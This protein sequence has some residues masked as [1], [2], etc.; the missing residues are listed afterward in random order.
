[1]TSTVLYFSIETPHLVDTPTNQPSPWSYAA[2]GPCCP[3]L[4]TSWHLQWLTLTLWKKTSLKKAWWQNI[5]RQVGGCRAQTSPSWE[6]RICQTTTPSSW[7]TLDLWGSDKTENGRSYTVRTSHDTLIRRNRVQLLLDS[8]VFNVIPLN[9][10]LSCKIYMK[11][12]LYWGCRWKW[13]MIIA[14]NFP[15]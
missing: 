7:K 14:V 11:F 5:L 4:T 1:M 3:P 9:K 2:L 15:I 8:F 6:L 10:F 12:I 13:R